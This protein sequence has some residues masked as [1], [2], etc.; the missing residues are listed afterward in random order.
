MNYLLDTHV[1]LWVLGEPKALSGE[2]RQLIQDPNPYVSQIFYCA[3]EY[4]R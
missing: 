2:A 3:P 4:R 1:F